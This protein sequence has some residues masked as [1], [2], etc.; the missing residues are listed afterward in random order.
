MQKLTENPSSNITQKVLKDKFGIGV[1]L[2]SNNKY[3]LLFFS[4]TH[5]TLG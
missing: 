3:S 5:L 4:F 2:D 1:P